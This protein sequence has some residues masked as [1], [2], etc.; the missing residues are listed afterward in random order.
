MQ[1]RSFIFLF[2][3]LFGSSYCIQG[4][5]IHISCR[6][7]EGKQFS[8]K[9]KWPISQFVNITCE[10]R[11]GGWLKVQTS[12]LGQLF[13]IVQFDIK[14]FDLFQNRKLCIIVVIPTYK[15][16][17][18]YPFFSSLCCSFPFYIP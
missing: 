9:S 2:V 3:F 7:V 13:G 10:P 18:M 14:L 4:S 8:C 1:L 17:A 15:F 11:F 5:T 12:N 6:N 16:G